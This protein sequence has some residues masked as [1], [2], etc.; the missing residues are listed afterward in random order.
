MVLPIFDHFLLKG[1]ATEGNIRYI[2]SVLPTVGMSRPDW[3]SWSPNE[4]VER[5]LDLCSR[6]TL[7]SACT[8]AILSPQTWLA[9]LTCS[10]TLPSL[11]ATR[12][13][14]R[15]LAFR[16]PPVRSV[17]LRKLGLLHRLLLASSLEPEL[18]EKLASLELLEDALRPL[19]RLLRRRFFRVR[20]SASL[21]EKLECLKRAVESSPAS[22]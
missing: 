4:P 3:V 14:L 22:V 12:R 18:L 19:F 11:S 1:M 6:S 7:F 15:L 9:L 17:Q 2:P 21:S 5:W 13:I 10:S 8:A 20:W 16:R